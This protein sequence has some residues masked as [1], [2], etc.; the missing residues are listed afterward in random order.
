MK[1][2]KNNNEEIAPETI[3]DA[4]PVT[5]ENKVDDVILPFVDML[6]K[7]LLDASDKISE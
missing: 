6:E 3:I 4:A 7:A 5:P 2:E 1:K